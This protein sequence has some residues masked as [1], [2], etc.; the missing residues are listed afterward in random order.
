MARLEPEAI[1]DAIAGTGWDRDED[2]LVRRVRAA[3]FVAAVALIDRLA[4]LAERLDHHPDLCLERYRHLTIRLTSH[5]A[6]GVTQ[7]D[8]RFVREAAALLDPLG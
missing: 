3:D 1:D 8:L 7:R 5:D 6:G 2:A 4:E